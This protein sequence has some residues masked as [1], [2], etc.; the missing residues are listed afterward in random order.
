MAD[1][2]NPVLMLMTVAGGE[3]FAASVTAS[4]GAGAR[5]EAVRRVGL[6]GAGVEAL[7]SADA[8]VRRAYRLL[9]REKYIDREVEV[10][11]RAQADLANL[12]GRS[13]DLA[14]AIAFAAAL[15]GADG[16]PCFRLPPLSATG[17]LNDGGGVDAVEG[18]APKIT[19]A[20]EA[21]PVGGV[22]LFPRANEG[23]VGA[24]LRAL[25]AARG[26][27]LA[28]VAR[29]EEAFQRAGV[30]LSRTWLDCPFRGLEPFEFQHASVFFGREQEIEDLLALLGRRTASGQNALLIEGA[31]GA[32][33]SSLVL[34]GVLP[35]L[36][37]RGVPGVLGDT[38]R[39]GLLRPH[40]VTADADPDREREALAE[41]FRAAWL[42]GEQGGLTPP[43]QP[44]PA[45][46]D[47]LD[48]S[49]LL[50]WLGE[51]AGSGAVGF[52]LVLDQME[53]WFDGRL[54][55]PTA[56]ALASLVVDLAARGVWV[57]ATATKTA[58]AGL[59]HPALAAAFGVE[60]RYQ[61]AAQLGPARLEAIIQGPAKAAR[62]AFEPGLDAELFAAAG[63][64]GS[65]VLPLLELLL[66]ELYER[67]DRSSNVLRMSDYRAVGGL[68]G[69]V[70]ARAEAVYEAASPTK[71]DA[72]APL[73]WKLETTGGLRPLDYPAGGPMLG[74]VTALL[75]RRLL[76]QDGASDHSASIRF[77]H[78]ALLR[79][80]RR[81]VELRNADAADMGLWRDLIRE[82]G[83]WRRRER[84]LIASG[85]QLDAARQVYERRLMQW[86]PSDAPVIDYV[87]ASVAARSRR[88]VLTAFAV[89]VPSTAAGVMAAV[90]FPRLVEAMNMRR[91]RFDDA[92]VA[93][94]RFEVEAGPFLRI[95]GLSIAAMSPPGSRLL[96]QG[97]RGLYEGRAM[98][99]GAK[100]Q[101][102]LTQ[103]AD[104]ATA[105][106][107]FTLA[108]DYPA[109]IVSLTRAGLWAATGSG[110]THPAWTATGY[111]AAGTQLDT[112]GEDLRRAFRIEDEAG[113]NQRADD[114]SAKTFTL[115]AGGDRPIHRVQIT[116]DF[117]LN[118]APFAGFQAVLLHEIQL[119]F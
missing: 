102:F 7:A 83:Q 42:H 16:T 57:L 71:Q 10:R 53:Q 56:A 101:H 74:L 78:E 22:V 80:W 114:I 103:M 13:A 20:M 67:R 18:L 95:H 54:Q 41:A 40:V 86:T 59:A 117:R 89:G 23:E 49:A 25:A 76:V 50:S 55:P 82:A 79:H 21:L 52:V 73:I 1:H 66:T 6:H 12:H 33:K 72:L 97:D 87:R 26:I 68:D 46:A 110:V 35:A 27:V 99:K 64:G 38:L 5:G 17:V 30:A 119:V 29:L 112:V 70:S 62:L 43:R 91:I 47:R 63:H 109:R 9:H 88:Q 2:A 61:L 116:S 92:A 98:A 105:P 85:P 4:I 48:A 8:G 94:P 60:G 58:D 96:I 39:W 34:A 36:L 19:A 115:E 75:A 11:V 45:S 113:R 24:D 93:P 65:D 106:I 118:G 51:A 100:D 3:G 90:S 37:R 31:S 69:V 15:C 111:D 104:P 32:G 28:P 107:S 108:L 44:A 81:A 14:F 77:A 84:S